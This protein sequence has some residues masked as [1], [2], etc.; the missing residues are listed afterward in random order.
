MSDS[1]NSLSFTWDD[2][3]RWVEQGLI[4]P[5]QALAIRQQVE[6][7]GRSGDFAWNKP[8]S[9][10]LGDTWHTCAGYL[11]HPRRIASPRAAQLSIPATDEATIRDK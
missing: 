1:I 6:Q 7:V 11:P 4:A 2:I 9:A 10:A 8:I 3:D 5:D